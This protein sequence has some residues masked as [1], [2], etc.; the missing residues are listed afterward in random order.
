MTSL[1]CGW[2]DC[3]FDS[4]LYTLQYTSFSGAHIQVRKCSVGDDVMVGSV[5][6]HA[7]S[8]RGFMLHIK[9][10]T[11]IGQFVHWGPST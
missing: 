8:E 2:H 5:T 6:Y 4:A 9:D 7:Q 3:I 1:L 10:G 11:S